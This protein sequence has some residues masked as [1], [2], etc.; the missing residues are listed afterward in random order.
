MLSDITMIHGTHPWDN[1]CCSIPKACVDEPRFLTH[2]CGSFYKVTPGPTYGPQ[3]R[4]PRLLELG[5]LFFVY[6]PNQYTD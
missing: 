4:K 1:G 5:L 3:R 6:L 2:F